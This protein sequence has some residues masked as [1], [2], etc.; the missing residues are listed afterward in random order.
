MANTTIEREIVQMVFDAKEFRKGIQDSIKDLSDFRKSFDFTSA[1]KSFAELESSSSS[2]DFGVMTN[3]ISSVNARMIAMG[4]IAADVITGIATSI[5]DAGKNIA[6]T[7]FITPAK[8]GLGEYET[9]LNAIQTILA[10]TKKHGT[11]LEDVTAALKELNDYADLTI[12]NFTE[13]TNNIGTFTTAGV[14]LETSVAAIKGIANA[15]A[16]S[17]ANATQAATAMYQLSQAVSS[18]VVRLQ[19][20][21]SVEKAGM[22]GEIFK[23]SLIETARLHGENVDLFIERE[24]SFRNSLKENWLSSEILL[25]TL[26]KFT[27]DLSKQ[28]LE[29]L[30]YTEEQIE[31]IIELGQMANDAAT[32]VKTFTALK[33]TLAEGLGSGWAQT[34]EIL[35]GDFEEAKEFWGAVA[36]FFGDI[37]ADSSNARNTLLEGWKMFGGRTIAIEGL[38]NLFE[39]G[40]NILATVGEAFR[41]IFGG[42]SSVDLLRLTIAF[43][44]FTERLKMASERGQRFKN[45]LRGLFALFDIGLMIIKAIVKPIAA[46][47]KTLLPASGEVL[48]LA[49]SVGMAIFY[50]REF[51]IETNLF[52]NIVADVIARVGDFIAKT[53]E[54]VDAFF[55]LEAVK[56]VI[57]WFNELKNADFVGLWKGVEK[58]VRAVIAPFYLLALGVQW[59]YK[60]IERLQLVGKI[61]EWFQEIDWEALA[62]YFTNISDSVKELVTNFKES[63]VIE[64]FVTL[65]KTFDGRRITQFVEDAKVAFG[66]LGGVIG[67]IRGLFGVAGEASEPIVS[68]LK[69]IGEGI[70]EGIKTVLDYL[71]N[72]A[73]NIDYSKV[74]D[75]INKG[76]FGAILLAI[77]NL[78]KGGLF[79][80]ILGED[81]SEGVSDAVEE[82]G[83]TLGAFQA[84]IKAD[85]LKKIATAIAI[86]AA[87]LFLM[88]L[89]DTDKLQM[90][91]VAIATMTA[92]LFGGAGALRLVDTKGSIQAALA[93]IA[94]SVALV[95]ASLALVNISHIDPD[96][97]TSSLEAM[98]VGL[99][100]LVLAVRGLSTGGAGGGGLL[101]TTGLLVGLSLALLILSTAIRTFGNMD[102]EV[103]SQGLLAVSLSLAALASASAVMTR[104][105]DKGMISAAIGI[106]IMSAALLV[107]G[108][109]VQAFGRMDVDELTQG[110]QS[111]GI[112]LAGVAGFSRVLD[113]R[114]MLSASLGVL[115]MSG[116]LIVM[117]IAVRRFSDLSWEE[118]LRGLAGLGVALLLVVVA[119]NLM[120]GALAGA[121]A[122]LVMSIALVAL[123]GALHLMSTLTWEELLIGLAAIAGVFI[124]LGV[125]GALLT[126]V[127]P[128]LLLLGVAMLL[129]GAGA[130][131]F[132]VGIFLAATGLVALAGAAVAIGAAI[133][134]VGEAII[135]ILPRLGAAIAEALVNF[136]VTIAENMPTIIEAFKDII[137]GM[138]GALVELIPE[139]VGAVLDLLTAVLERIAESLPDLIQAGYDILLAFIQ[140]IEDNIADVV[141]AGLGVLTEFMVGLEEGIPELVDQAFST[142][143]TFLEAIA[144]AIEEYMP[145]IVDAGL[146]IGEGII[147][148]LVQ[149]IT[150]GLGA[151]KDAVFAIARAALEALGLGFLWSSPSKKTYEIGEGFVE[152]FILAVIDGIAKTKAAMAKFAETAQDGIRPLVDVIDDELEFNPVITP[153]LD[154]DNVMAGVAMLDKSFDNSRVLAQLSYEGELATKED[155][156]RGVN[157]SDNGVTFIQHNYSP[158]ALDRE[159]IY[160][161]TRT[162]VA[163]LSEKAFR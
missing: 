44:D 33:D 150:G 17:G 87:S 21:M 97:I 127:I 95:I 161:Q 126:P 11:E 65:L 46:F 9:Q 78:I 112:I 14:K 6:S 92:A 139:M 20:W 80:G 134:I 43:R 49:S 155:S 160:R 121:F 91:T 83:D 156:I 68:K 77:R 113:S 136:L 143:L 52:D 8:Q 63:E 135:K 131:L 60:E 118:L 72:N 40:R 130:A 122:I 125:A 28:Q 163:R 142:L 79:G 75:L 27:G 53:K 51:A 102:P 120:S 137:L 32:K 81:I 110:L 152:G 15:A 115:A 38:F 84:N 99:A 146:R 129:I 117:S 107:L 159:T 88:T 1:H 3:G 100:G 48:D 22:G 141:A 147:D 94:L 12:Y 42:V 24:G 149:A 124:I 69:E 26:A 105:G 61:V 132:G 62:G 111:V 37:I 93:I 86:L 7:L 56:K 140:G 128:T 23:Q 5:V 106:T 34:W 138:I 67:G 154:L 116:A 148:G 29:S 19:D 25:D 162:Q 18:G 59:L 66:E 47:V 13:M 145:Q 70:V 58:G 55:E 144:D 96:Q 151:V 35:L 39:A 153:V 30:G 45:F 73:E 158:K 74:F 76:L 50:F 10:N 31:G 109:S 82:L 36:E 123:A 101:K 104:I 85:T 90:A 16:L 114:G 108:R 57:A 41:D 71:I 64:K 4:I 98:A 119:A 133:G 89:I 103:L 2:M 157:G 54:L